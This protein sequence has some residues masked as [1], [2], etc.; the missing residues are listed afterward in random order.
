M[1]FS[2]FIKD[3]LDAIVRDWE[4][5]A[6]TLPA[7][8]SMS[9]L[10]LR[11]HSREILLAIAGEMELPQ[12]EQERASQAQDI[13]PTEASTTSAAAASACF[14]RPCCKALSRRTTGCA[15]RRWLARR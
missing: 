10:A 15:A 14:T 2:A 13:V 12:S 11:D 4:A 3:N 6:R 8:Q 9:A 7:G 1:K 5:F